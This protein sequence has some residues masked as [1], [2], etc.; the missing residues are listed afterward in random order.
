M[1]LFIE[2]QRSFIGAII[3]DPTEENLAKFKENLEKLELEIVEVEEQKDG[4][5]AY[6]PIG[7][8][9]RRISISFAPMR[10]KI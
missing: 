2:K 8:I 7:T 10:G 5:Q 6:H 9:F 4:I 3:I 1:L